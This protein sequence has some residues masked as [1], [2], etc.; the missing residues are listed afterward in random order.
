MS[1]DADRLEADHEREAAGEEQSREGG[2]ERL[3]VEVLDEHAD[4]QA[5]DGAPERAMTGIA[6]TRPQPV[7]RAVGQQDRR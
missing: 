5:D 6:T 1:S 7:A 2:D 3:N 4:E